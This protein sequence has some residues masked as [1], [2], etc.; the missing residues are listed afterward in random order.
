MEKSLELQFGGGMLGQHRR[1][2]RHSAQYYSMAECVTM[3]LFGLNWHLQQTEN[4]T[5]ENGKVNADLMPT[6]TVSLPSGDNG[7][8]GGFT[9]ENNT[10]D[11]GELDI[12]RRAIQEVPP[13]VFWRSQLFIDQPQFLKFN[14]S[15]QKDALIGVY[16]RK[17]LPPSH[18]QVRAGGWH[19]EDAGLPPSHTKVRV[20]V[21]ISRMQAPGL[22][23][24]DV[25]LTQKLSCTVKPSLPSESFEIEA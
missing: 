5:F 14:I 4:D 25:T 20:G 24:L 13:G 8:L 19:Q 2:P 3:H 17:G 18:T 21:G 15:L 11:S 1:S 6:N 16:G 7:K 12:G 22:R 23:F 10:I 9:H